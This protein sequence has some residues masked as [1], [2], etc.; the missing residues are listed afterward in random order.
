MS[1]SVPYAL[2]SYRVQYGLN[3]L[4]ALNTKFLDI[5]LGESGLVKSVPP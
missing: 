4:Q 5:I 3:L 1:T 2:T